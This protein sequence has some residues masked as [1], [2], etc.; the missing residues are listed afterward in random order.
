MFTYEETRDTFSIPHDIRI[1]EEV[2]KTPAIG[3]TR[4]DFETRPLYNRKNAF[5]TA[6]S[7]ADLVEQLDEPHRMDAR[8]EVEALKRAY[9]TLSEAYQSDKGH[10]GI[11]LA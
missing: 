4:E 3:E 9:N 10:A 6:Q 11:P 7:V 5:W 8:K 2:F 1:L